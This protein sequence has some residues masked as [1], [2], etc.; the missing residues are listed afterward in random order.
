MKE[1]FKAYLIERSTAIF[2]F[3]ERDRESVLFQER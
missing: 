2:I 1:I 3:W